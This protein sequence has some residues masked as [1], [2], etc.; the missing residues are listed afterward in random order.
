MAKRRKKSMPIML[1]W[2]KRDQQR[3]IDGAERMLALV[4]DLET[5]VSRLDNKVMALTAR[6]NGRPSR[7][8]DTPTTPEVNHEPA[9]R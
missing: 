9:Q 3:F 1:F 5:L 6:R 4:N 2:S 8:S 7:K